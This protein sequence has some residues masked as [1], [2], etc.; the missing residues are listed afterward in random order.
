M[1]K[2]WPLLVL[3]SSAN[4]CAE[5]ISRSETFGIVNEA[6]QRIANKQHL[7]VDPQVAESLVADLNVFASTFCGSAGEF[8]V[9]CDRIRNNPAISTKVIGDYLVDVVK[10]KDS[11]E[12][13]ASRFAKSIGKS[14]TEAG[15]PEN[16]PSMIGVFNVP[17]NLR[18]AR[19]RVQTATEL[20]DIGDH[21]N[22]ILF[23]PGRYKL[24]AVLQDG[25]TRFG[26]LLIAPRA[27]GLWIEGTSTDA[28]M[29]GR[30]DV[31]PSSYCLDLPSTTSAQALNPFNWARSVIRES[32]EKRLAHRT[33]TAV[34]SSIEIKVVDESGSCSTA[35][36]SGLS[37]AFAQAIAVWRAGCQPCDRGALSI[38]K[39]GDNVWMD[40]RATQRIL[41]LA[42]RPDTKLNLDL[43][44]YID[45]EMQ[46]YVTVPSRTIPSSVMAGYEQVDQNVEVT[47][48][49]C[50]QAAPSGKNWL[51]AAQG[52]LC[53]GFVRLD[54]RLNPTIIIKSGNTECGAATEAIA[55]SKPGGEIQLTVQGYAY[56]IPTSS[57]TYL[58]GSQ[59]A[60][61]ELDL[62]PVI[63][64]EVGHWFGVPHPESV[65]ILA[66]DIMQG[67]FNPDSTCVRPETLTLLSNA[68]DDRWPFIA[69]SKQ[70][71]RPP[72]KLTGNQQGAKR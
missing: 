63:L 55:C 3:M 48:V 15:W 9:K 59:K 64:H 14:V 24:V 2:L 66:P 56:R 70:G 60:P 46:T 34:Q 71:L 32:P 1:M 5:P 65:G 20:V 35:C 54:E 21:L 13:V 11:V 22:T 12:S 43:S 49:L 51:R 47:R 58:L 19:F 53:S 37:I 52:F 38:V 29:L 67:T 6:L 17:R 28:K 33:P 31:P 40:S 18:N 50:K 69:K 57:G 26:R 23:K 44:K 61:I 39:L 45:A 36:Q 10:G 8:D 30:I 42:H 7:G 72:T 16:I 68:V 4:V 41:A 27:N 25:R 62:G